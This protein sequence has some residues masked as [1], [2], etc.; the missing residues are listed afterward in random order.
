MLSISTDDAAGKGDPGRYLKCIADAGF[1]HVHWCHHWHGDFLYS[2]HEIDQIIRWYKE[3]GLTPH[4]VH[5]T[6]GDENKWYSA[7][8]YQRLSGVELV[9][10]R[11][12]LAQRIGTDV[13]V[14]HVPW[15][16]EELDPLRMSLDTLRL[17][18][19]E[20]GVHLAVE[21][22]GNFD[23]LKKLFSEYEPEYIGLCYDAGHGNMDG[24]IEN[25]ETV[26]DRL[27]IMHLHDNNGTDDQHNPIF[28]G[29]LDWEQLAGVLAKSRCKQPV[30]ME[31]MRAG[32]GFDDETAFLAHVYETGE[33]FSEMM[34][35]VRTAIS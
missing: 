13:V 27:L 31:I 20:R 17:F 34:E 11:I 4:G 24:D 25:L 10:N 26:L 29:T 15:E 28:S 8:D 16:A 32:S 7:K 2:D 30:N 21:N 9:Q 14:M 35:T 1:S 19:A 6:D 5:G 3:F 18:A 33:P 23:I 22:C 12:H